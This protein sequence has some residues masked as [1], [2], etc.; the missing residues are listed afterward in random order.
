M[1]VIEA[2]IS[3]SRKVNLGNYESADVFLSFK[4][5][6]AEEDDYLQL[7]RAKFAEA[8]KLVNEQVAIIEGR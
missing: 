3:R 2:S 8:R 1:K 5:E 6:F 7:I 4:L